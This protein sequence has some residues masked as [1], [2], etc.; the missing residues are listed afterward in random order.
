M[1]TVCNKRLFMRGFTLTEFLVAG[2]LGSLLV[3][4]MS[5]FIGASWQT[6]RYQ[7]HLTD[8]QEATR[9][10]F[11]TIEQNL[12]LARSTDTFPVNW[13][14]SSTHDSGSDQLSLTYTSSA[15]SNKNCLGN[16]ESGI[17]TNTYYIRPATDSPFQTH[18]MMCSANNR[19]DT[20]VQQIE[21]MK[22]RYGIDKGR[23]VNHEF[24]YQPDGLIDG[25]VTEI[26]EAKQHEVVSMEIVLITRSQFIDKSITST[27]ANTIWDKSITDFGIDTND[28]YFR[29][30]HS[31]RFN[32]ASG[33]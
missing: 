29:R 2:L 10:F 5:H 26:N 24:I 33:E 25:W 9:T 21:L 13:T 6:L 32:F 11:A 27:T 30:S 1:K 18:D 22:V 23:F 3:L 20:I 12:V 19:S 28:G 14:A 7:M 31:A 16:R 15:R 4:G 17:I 8:M